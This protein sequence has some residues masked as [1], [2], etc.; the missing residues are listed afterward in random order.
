[1][2][3]IISIFLIYGLLF[4]A[5]SFWKKSANVRNE[6]QNQSEVIIILVRIA[7]VLF[8]IALVFILNALWFFPVKW[9]YQWITK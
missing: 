6:M 7:Y 3:L 5:Y 8:G 9:F 2:K 4:M 1:M